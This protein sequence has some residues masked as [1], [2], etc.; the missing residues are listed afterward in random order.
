MTDIDALR[1]EKEL[2]ESVLALRKQIENS[3]A[4]DVN[5]LNEEKELLQTV[6]A[7]RET[8]QEG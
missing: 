6:L 1:E 3:D 4:P 7:L 5:S 8:E 2:L